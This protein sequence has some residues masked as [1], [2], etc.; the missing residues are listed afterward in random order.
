MNDTNV[1]DNSVLVD[2]TELEADKALK[3]GVLPIFWALKS[4]VLSIVSAEPEK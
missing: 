2:I 3:S 1:D 4:K